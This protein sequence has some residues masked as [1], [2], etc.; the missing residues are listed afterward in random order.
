MFKQLFG[1]KIISNGLPGIF[2]LENDSQWMV[3]G[4]YVAPSIKYDDGFVGRYWAEEVKLL[5]V[6]ATA[7]ISRAVFTMPT[8]RTVSWIYRVSGQ[9]VSSLAGCLF[10]GCGCVSCFDPVG[11]FSRT[12]FCV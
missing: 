1:R 10:P 7:N 6:T 12:S 4:M 8:A 9:P 11:F 5:T 3:T 2:W